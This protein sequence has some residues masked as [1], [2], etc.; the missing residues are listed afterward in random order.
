MTTQ[1]IEATKAYQQVA[2]DFERIDNSKPVFANLM[3][4]GDTTVQGDVHITLLDA[5]IAGGTLAKSRQLA[6][7]TTQGSR[8][9]ATGDCDVLNVPKD[10]AIEALNRLIPET[11]GLQLFVGPMIRAIGDVTV[12]HPEHA[13]QTL[14]AGSCYL[15][16]IQRSWAAEVRRAQD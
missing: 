2:R 8:H 5:E 4:A 10:Q 14:P 1:T 11:R 13:W 6:P 7:G 15:V 12:E 3:S 16:T 9:F